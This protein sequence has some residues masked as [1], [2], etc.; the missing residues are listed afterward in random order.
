M[1][2]KVGTSPYI[3]DF[4]SAPTKEAYFEAIPYLALH[5]FDDQCTSANPRYPLMP[6]LEEIFKVIYEK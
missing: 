6:E 2:D 3:K 5:A 4:R 1:Y